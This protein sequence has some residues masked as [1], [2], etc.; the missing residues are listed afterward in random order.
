MRL[1]PSMWDALSAISER[2][3]RSV[4]DL[5]T[6]IDGRHGGTAMTSAV[7]V[8]VLAYYQ[9][10]ARE[11]ERRLLDAPTTA[12]QIKPAGSRS[13]ATALLDDIFA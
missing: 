6:A 12:N 13:D 7:R 11:M 9:R 3:G 10:L 5:A 2:E 8:F 4:N 1:E